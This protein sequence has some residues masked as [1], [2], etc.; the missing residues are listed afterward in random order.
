MNVMIVVSSRYYN[1]YDWNFLQIYSKGKHVELTYID[2]NQTFQS[3]LLMS[4][5]PM[6]NYFLIIEPSRI[7]IGL[8]IIFR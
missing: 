1:L 2:F 6:E 8:K 4:L 7:I 3:S 5:C